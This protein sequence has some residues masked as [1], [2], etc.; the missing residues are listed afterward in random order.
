MQT[1]P[2]E[3]PPTRWAEPVAEGDGGPRQS[4]KAKMVEWWR[5]HYPSEPD[6][7]LVSAVLATDTVLSESNQID[8][9]M[10]AAQALA[11]NRR[12][13]DLEALVNGYNEQQATLESG[14]RKTDLVYRALTLPHT[15]REYYLPL[16]LQDWNQARPKAMV[17]RLALT[18]YLQHL[19]DSGQTPEFPRAHLI[20]IC[21]NKPLDYSGR[22]LTEAGTI[23]ADRADLCAFSIEQLRLSQG[24]PEEARKLW[25]RGLELDPTSH[26][27]QGQYARFLHSRGQDWRQ[28]VKHPEDLLYI[29][30]YLPELEIPNDYALD[31]YRKTEAA[32]P[33]STYVRNAVAKAAMKAGDFKLAAEEFNWLGDR[34]ER[35]VWRPREYYRA[36]N[37]LRAQGLPIKA[38]V[39]QP[40]PARP[41]ECQEL[42][43]IQAELLA[44]QTIE[45]FTGEFY[46]ELEA[47]A[48]AYRA[49]QQ[50]FLNGDGKLAVLYDSI[51]TDPTGLDSWE[52]SVL[53]QRWRK[54]KPDSTT[55]AVLSLRSTLDE[56]WDI[57]GYDWASTVTEEQWKGFRERLKQARQYLDEA[58]KTPTPKDPF[59][60]AAAITLCL[61]EG[62]PRGQADQYLAKASQLDP[63]EPEP[64]RAM[65]M[66]LLPR[67]HGSRQ[68][69]HAFLDGL[70]PE[71]C[72][73]VLNREL[74]LAEMNKKTA[75]QRAAKGYVKYAASHPNRETWSRALIWS[76]DA[77]DAELSKLCLDNM[78]D[79]DWSPTYIPSQYAFDEIGE[80]V[81][82]AGK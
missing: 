15:K 2:T 56:A 37:Q 53:C 16:R 19:A 34:V 77:D 41:P 29:Q 45:L 66:Y 76:S 71:M 54:V 26:S 40:L 55:A 1:T 60:Y 17:P 46:A 22:F 27:V 11:D 51:R 3:G 44:Y 9:F 8:A 67:W 62:A 42:E 21:L 4:D 48:D 64:Y 72:A 14:F 57:R 5:G 25:Q 12:W 31:C 28:A 63:W 38:S 78:G 47:V 80:W 79:G 39:F 61:G 32:H 6:R 36:R 43:G 20:L 52:R 7:R 24:D 49:R 69:L 58:E 73:M 82:K 23:Q 18:S 35:R 13:D 74:S 59:L 33:K 81:G 75:Q 68:E 30:A 10:L 70:T 65:F 50:R